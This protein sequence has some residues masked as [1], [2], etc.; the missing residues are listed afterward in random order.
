M[1]YETLAE[2]RAAYKEGQVSAPLT[3]DNDDTHAYSGGGCVFRM[4]PA[5]LLEQAL[6]L[7]FLGLSGENVA[8]MAAGEPARVKKEDL[9][10]LGLPE[11]VVVIAYGR[12]EQDIIAELKASGVRLHGLPEEQERPPATAEEKAL[13]EAAAGLDLEGVADA[14]LSLAGHLAHVISDAAASGQA[15]ALIR[16]R[17]A[18]R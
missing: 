1:R 2:L 16:R 13:D 5:E 9:Q 17:E 12:T 11:M 14:A 3:I 6:D 7:L 15:N 18:L 10:E 8:R 4:H